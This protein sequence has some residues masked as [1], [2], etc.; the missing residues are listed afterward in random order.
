MQ[1]QW[2]ISST[3]KN[4]LRL[5]IGSL[6]LTDVRKIKLSKLACWVICKNLHFISSDCFIKMFTFSTGVTIDAYILN[7]AATIQKRRADPY[8]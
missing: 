8:L 7:K 1:I 5:I 3:Y 6:S 2:E 4:M